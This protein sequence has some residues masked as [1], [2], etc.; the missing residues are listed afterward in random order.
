MKRPVRKPAKRVA[1]KK[2][3]SSPA[4]D[5]AAVLAASK[6]LRDAI[7][8]GETAAAG[9]F[10][11]KDFEFVDAS[12][13]VHSRAEVLAALKASPHGM[14]DVK[15]RSYGR[16][17]MVTGLR[18]SAQGTDLYALDVWIRTP[19]GWRALIHHNN[20]LA[21]D[22]APRAHPA[23][24]PRPPDAPPPDCAN[25]LQVVPYAPTSKAERDIIASF[26]ALE[27][28]VTRNDADTWVKHMADEF[29]V[30][31]TGQHPTTRAERAG[32]LHAQREVNAE[33][34]VAEVAAM[35]LWVLGDAAV[36]RAD[37]VMPDNRR[38]PYRATRV[39]VKRDGRWQ[40]A[41]SQQ[42]TRVE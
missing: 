14:S 11:A 33:T 30:T 29:V 2:A 18:K 34:W 9:K 12:G 28:A 25:P 8:L 5:T 36:M 41:V 31:R 13:H 19:G 3:G 26:Q 42:T 21:Q 40:M 27:T 39:W 20:S 15:V 16:V 7:R 6:A 24:K 35:K 32:H 1:A 38:P 37:H 10:L 4:R 22:D 23:P 17:A